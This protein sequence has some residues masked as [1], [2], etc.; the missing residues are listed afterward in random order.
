MDLQALFVQ[1]EVLMGILRI[2]AEL[3]LQ[4]SWLAAGTLCN[5]VWNVLSGKAGLTQASDLDV[6]FYDVNMSYDEMLALQQDLQQH[7]PA[8]Q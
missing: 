6:V 5:Y 2:I 4:D 3:D 8:Y 1:D 7:Y